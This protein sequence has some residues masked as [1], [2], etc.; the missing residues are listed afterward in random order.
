VPPH[1]VFHKGNN[2]RWRDVLTDEDLQRYHDL[3]AR[4]LSADAMK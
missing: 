2:G 1:G 3:K 4:T